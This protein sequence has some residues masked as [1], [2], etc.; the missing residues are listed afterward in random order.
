MDTVRI[1]CP[2]CRS[3]ISNPD[4]VEDM[5]RCSSCGKWF[6]PSPKQLSDMAIP[7]A[8][9]VPH[10]AEID[11]AQEAQTQAQKV[12][13]TA[14]RFVGIAIACWIVA[15]LI[16]VFGF[17]STVAENEG[18]S[19]SL[20]WILPGAGFLSLGLWLYLIGQIVHIRANLEK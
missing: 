6:K 20:G 15:G 3:V 17:M 12:R 19:A 1:D 4:V 2:H 7:P 11:A 18:F 5:I 14:Q 10:F 13:G 16:W 9:I 8:P